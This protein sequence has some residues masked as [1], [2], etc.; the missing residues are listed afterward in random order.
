[1]NSFHR[2]SFLVTE[3]RVSTVFLRR[4]HV[5][6]VDCALRCR[7]E[8]ETASSMGELGQEEPRLASFLCPQEV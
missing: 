4:D 1:M 7:G 3:K 2:K 8:S 5:C 6:A